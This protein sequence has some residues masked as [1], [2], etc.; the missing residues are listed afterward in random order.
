MIGGFVGDRLSKR[1]IAA[2]CMGMHT[3]GLLLLAVGTDLPTILG[4]A[5][6]HGL[7][8]GIR[9]PLMMAVRADY[10]GRRSFATIEGIA[11]FIVTICAVLGPLL[12]GIMADQLGD[13]RP[14]L[15]T[16]AGITSLGILCFL[17]ARRPS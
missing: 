3:A 5:T 15:V 9:G 7:A 4:F 8:W 14:S 6:L 17:F 16:L 13:Y 12:V 10:F 1:L 2:A 11:S